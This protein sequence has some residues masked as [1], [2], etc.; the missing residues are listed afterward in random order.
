MWEKLRTMILCNGLP[1]FQMGYCNLPT[2]T[3]RSWWSQWV[4]TAAR[5][6]YLWSRW[7]SVTLWVTLIRLWLH[8][9]SFYLLCNFIDMSYSLLVW[10]F[11]WFFLLSVF[12][13][14]LLSLAI[15]FYYMFC[16]ASQHHGWVFP[17]LLVLWQ[18]LIMVAN[19]CNWPPSTARIWRTQWGC[20]D[21]W[22]V[23]LKV[24]ENTCDCCSDH[25]PCLS[26][27]F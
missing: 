13:L 17:S 22:S 2:P 27:V 3:I 14:F 9:L 8:S 12:P 7:W 16:W 24:T 21:S 15:S 23:L 5:H 25:T 11:F 6:C 18:K 1:R 4:V 10:V 26:Y 20:Y 19:V